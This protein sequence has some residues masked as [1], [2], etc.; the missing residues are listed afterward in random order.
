MENEIIN[1][2]M[3][4][5]TGSPYLSLTI[6][7]AVAEFVTRLLIHQNSVKIP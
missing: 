6:G 7:I 5:I 3:A 2:G 4:W 1:I